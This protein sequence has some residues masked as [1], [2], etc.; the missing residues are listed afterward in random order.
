[1]QR[2]ADALSTVLRISHDL[3]DALT[4]DHGAGR[5]DSDHDAGYLIVNADDWGRDRETTART[6]ACV[7]H[8]TVSSVSAMVF[9]PDSERAAEIAQEHRIDAGLHLNFTTPFSASSCTVQLR[10]RQRELAAYLTQ[11]RL[12]RIVFHPRLGRSFEYVCEAQLDE[13]C[14]LYGK[15]PDRIDGHHHMH[16]CSNVLLGGLLPPATIVRRNFSFQPGEKGLGNRLYRKTVDRVLARRHRIADFLFSL[17]PLAPP[18]RLPRIFS[19]A[20]EFVVEVETHPVHPEEYSLL[21]GEEIFQLTVDIS[22]R[23]FATLR[24]GRMPA[25]A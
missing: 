16:L 20:R 22:I 21:M 5:C 15:T 24:A 6:L 18:S 1:M 19:L 14:R 10:E 25:N 23:G 7:L 8:R 12:A 2:T 13:F 17:L 4:V 11:H 3:P 9:M